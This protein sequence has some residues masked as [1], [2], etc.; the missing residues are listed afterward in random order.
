M[1][2]VF[3]LGHRF[4]ENENQVRENIRASLDYFISI[5]GQIECISN[6]AC[7][8]DTI[9][10]QEAI[11]KKCKI[12]LVLPFQI[13]EYEKDF[14]SESLIL[15][16]SI[17]AKHAYIVHG[18]LKSSDDIERDLAYQSVGRSKI[19]ECDA[20]LAVWDGEI[21]K[22]LG[23]TK[24]HVDYAILKEKDLHWIKAKRVSNEDVPIDSASIEYNQFY[25]LDQSAIKFKAKYQQIWKL[26]LIS[27]IFAVLCFS[28]NLNFISNATV[29]EKAPFIKFLISIVE[30][31]FIGI[32][33]YL[34]GFQAMKFKSKF[35]NMRKNAEELR[36]ELWK[37]EISY[38]DIIVKF[39]LK[40]VREDELIN[41]NLKRLL[42]GYSND[43]IIYQNKRITRFKSNL[44]SIHI[45]LNVLKYC[46][47][48]NLIFISFLEGSHW[49][50]ESGH[51]SATPFSGDLLHILFFLWILIPPIFATLEGVI[52][53]NDW[54]KNSQ[55]SLE[56]VHRY[57][58]VKVELSSSNDSISLKNIINELFNTFTLEVNTWLIEQKNNEI[59]A[60]I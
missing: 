21:G 50:H 58:K 45:I 44:H 29:E 17:I 36:A 57:E 25:E 30:L 27:G 3:G 32:S 19:E 15:F 60:K 31:I 55:T 40:K 38:L 34:L 16:R 46:F 51:S 4:L 10:I 28:I 11:N 47:L 6:L 24:D 9:F 13:N 20:I 2:K 48:I 43:Q 52:H 37:R 53:Y 23:G 5:H 7:G 59:K 54:K 49:L 12:Q 42:W 35:L 26:G 41:M 56:L 1:Y 18:D 14:D 22:G 39:R 33:F 8:A